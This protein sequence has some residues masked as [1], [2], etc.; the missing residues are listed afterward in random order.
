MQHHDEIDRHIEAWTKTFPPL[1]VEQRLRGAGVPAEHMR[2]M[3]EILPNGNDGV[4][5]LLPA[6][7]RPTL[8]TGLPFRFVP[9]KKQEFGRAPRLGEDTEDGLRGWLGL[10][11]AAIEKLRSDRVLL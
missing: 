8:L 9:H 11:T 6:K 2:R 1:E 3:D 7:E 5:H 10:E 4:F